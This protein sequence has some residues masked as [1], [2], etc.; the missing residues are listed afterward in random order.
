M[1]PRGTFQRD[2]FPSAAIANLSGSILAGPPN[3][4][5]QDRNTKGAK[6]LK[7][8]IAVKDKPR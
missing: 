8:N 3:S 4:Q 6:G 1:I 7:R 5:M 2:F